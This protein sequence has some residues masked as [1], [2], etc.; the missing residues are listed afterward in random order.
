MA[1]DLDVVVFMHPNGFTQGDRLTDHYFT[2]VIGNPLDTTVAARPL[3]FD[4]RARA[5]PEAQA[6]R[7]PRRR[8]HRALPGADGPRV[9]RAGRRADR[10]QED[11]RAG[12][13]RRVY[14]DTIV[15]DREQLEHLVNLWGAD[16][17]LVGTD[18]P[19]DMGMYDPRGFVDGGDVPKRR[20]IEAKIKGLNAAK[21]LKIKARPRQALIRGILARVRTLYREDAMARV[22]GLGHVGI[23]VRDLERMVAFYR[24]VLG[25]QI[26]KQNWRAGVVFLSADPEAVD[27]EIA[28]MRG[29]PDRPTRTSSTR[30][31]CGCASLDDLRAFHRRLVAEGYRIEGVV[32]HASAIGCYFFDPEGN[33]TEVFW[34]TGRPCWVPTANPIDIEQPDEVVLAEVDRV[35]N[36]LRHVPGGRADGPSETAT[37]SQADRRPAA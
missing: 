30:S 11:A 31:R 25:M 4:G 18:Y 3:V 32:N 9:G 17:V 26:T 13:W 35:W 1:Q 27:H 21:L 15:F 14:F 28:L 2:N 22:L 6:R 7:R 20:R 19:Y 23:Y 33:R 12:R 36:E 24:D 5:L 29:R 16:H 37:R 34:V 8:L 10:A